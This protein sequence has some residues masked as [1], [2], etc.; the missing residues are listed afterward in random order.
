MAKT[1]LDNFSCIA[2]NCM[3]TGMPNCTFKPGFT[4]GVILTPK[5]KEYTKAEIAVLVETLQAA[6]VADSPAD[7][8]IPVKTFTTVEAADSEAVYETAGSSTYFVR[9][10][11]MGINA[12]I[13]A[14]ECLWKKLRKYNDKQNSFDAIIIDTTNNGFIATKTATGGFKGFSLD[15][16][17]VPQYKMATNSTVFHFMFKI[18][19][20]NIIEFENS[21]AVI[22]DNTL[23]VLDV[24][25]GLIDF[26]LVEHVALTN[27]GAY[28]AKVV[29]GCGT[30]NM[31]D[32][33]NAELAD[34]NAWTA[35]IDDTG[36]AITI[37]SVTAVPATET[38]T[39]ALTLP[40]VGVLPVGGTFTL[41]PAAPSV[42]DG[43]GISGYSGC[44]ITLV[45]P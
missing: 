29:A 39:F 20:A 18:V 26:T 22:L 25:N 1:F 12:R 2:D 42:L 14:S 15:Q 16:I 27:G 28:K 10:G 21:T 6:A 5:G 13:D 37:A 40:L 23:N 31:Y 44:G 11:K 33:Y 7:R 3:N 45:R 41:A 34:P 38:L 30:S 19:F 43:L 9:D 8:I 17:A 36:V 24:V 32:L 35:T 4:G